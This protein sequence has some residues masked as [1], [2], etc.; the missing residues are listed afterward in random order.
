[1]LDCEIEERQ[2]VGGREVFVCFFICLLHE[3][4]RGTRDMI[5]VNNLLLRVYAGGFIYTHTHTLPGLDCGLNATC[6]PICKCFSL[7]TINIPSM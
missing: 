4:E 3:R 7:L 2:R 6:Y 1:M 5:F